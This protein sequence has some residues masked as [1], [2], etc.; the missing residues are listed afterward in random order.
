LVEALALAGAGGIEER[1]LERI[2]I[3]FV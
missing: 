3:L 2:L 1:H